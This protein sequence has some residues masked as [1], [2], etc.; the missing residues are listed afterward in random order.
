MTNKDTNSASMNK[1]ALVFGASGLQG[2]Y[3]I[4]GLLGK[5]TQ[6]VYAASRDPSKV[7][8]AMDSGA[9][10]IKVDLQDP[11]SIGNSLRITKA[12]YIFL[13]A[14]TEIFNAHMPKKAQE[15]E[16]RCIQSF[17]D[18]LCRV[19]EEDRLHRH[20]IFSSFENVEKLNSQLSMED[21]N[22]IQPLED[23]SVVAH[24]S[25]RYESILCL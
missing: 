7:Q 1:P 15:N 22:Y 20:V 23:G 3:V 21:T 8:Y 18:V 14:T 16:F 6:P 17:F 11:H 19:Y 13:V 10:F 5:T 24:F 9:E 4:Q 2:K 12:K 25:G